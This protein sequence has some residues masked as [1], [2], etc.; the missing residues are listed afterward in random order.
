MYWRRKL[1]Q[2]V[3]QLLALKAQAY[4]KACGVKAVNK[5]F[6][7]VVIE[8]PMT[9]CTPTTQSFFLDRR[10]PYPKGDAQQHAKHFQILELNPSCSRLLKG[11]A[12]WLHSTDSVN[13]VL[14]S[15]T[16]RYSQFTV[17]LSEG[18]QG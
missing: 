7:S 14:H 11:A 8:D 1:R 9:W 16:R 4:L 12:V 5:L 2:Q 15:F 6:E 3:V 17:Q 18:G 13:A 10:Y